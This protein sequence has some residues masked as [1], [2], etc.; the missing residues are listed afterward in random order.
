MSRPRETE[1]ARLAAEHA[2]IERLLNAYLRERGEQDPR[3][4]ANHTPSVEGGR[5]EIRLPSVRARMEGTL[6][7]YSAFGHHQYGK[8]LWLYREADGS[9]RLVTSALELAKWL[10]AELGQ[11]TQGEPDAERLLRQLGHSLDNMTR[12]LQEEP[13]A[14]MSHLA[15]GYAP[16][17]RSAEQSLL[18][19]HPFHPTPKSSEGFSDADKSSYAPELGGTFRLHYFAA[20]SSF[21]H[22]QWLS[23]GNELFSPSVTAGAKA[24]LGA[25][26]GEFA[27][28]PAHPWQAAFLLTKPEVQELLGSGRLIHLGEL[29]EEV[30]AT[31][32]VRTVCDPTGAYMYK[33]PLN[34]RI[35]HFVRV[36]PVEQLDRTIEAGRAV[37][38]AASPLPFPNFRIIPEDGFRTI[39]DS[40]TGGLGSLS[41][42]FGVVFRRNPD[43]KTGGPADHPCVLAALLEADDSGETSPLWLCVQQAAKQRGTAA[44]LPFVAAW[45]DEYVRLSLA[46]LLWLFAEQGIS[47]EAHAQ[48][49]LLTLDKGWP[50]RFY[51]RDLEGASICAER[52]EEL[53]LSPG[54]PA[55]YEAEEAW[56]R[57]RYY[58]L[59][60]QLGHVVHAL[61]RALRQDERLLWQVVRNSLQTSD[62]LRADR[63]SRYVQRLIGEHHWPAKANLLSWA[64]GHGE[65][66]LYV[67]IKNP[68]R[69][70]CEEEG[71]ATRGEAL[72][73][74]GY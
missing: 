9:R 41:E 47:L 51:V 7:W 3:S 44:D 68:L 53:G 72:Y 61:G 73:E 5:M 12:Y 14:L 70:H 45:L 33:L 23:Q 57:F 13:S 11:E 63:A 15:S 26:A 27:L 38:A 36:N 54:H 21:V 18:R 49:T 39:D 28:L 31:S 71:Q 4:G 52:G 34:I 74:A 25:A 48:N 6:R 67:P 1:D 62:S 17:M 10:L 64:R 58:V 8:E 55:L 37:A 29:G 42:S 59:V 24:R 22:E 2:H 40:K 65:T 50:T 60:N 30:Y 56:R 69:S 19:G 16:D 20:H 46:P 66:P 32:S 35:T 43:V